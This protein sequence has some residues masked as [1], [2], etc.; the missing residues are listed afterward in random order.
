[1]LLAGV[2]QFKELDSGQN[3]S[4]QVSGREACRNDGGGISCF[5][6]TLGVMGVSREE[7]L[8][9]DDLHSLV[10]SLPELALKWG[11][12]LA[13]HTTFRVGGPVFCL[14]RPWTEGALMRLMQELT[15]LEAPYFILGGGSNLLFPDDA[16]NGL[17]IQLDLCSGNLGCNHQAGASP[18]H[19]L[20]GAGVRLS[21]L[22]RFCLSN[23]LGGIEFLVGI[24]GTVGGALVMNAGTTAG[25]IGDALLWIDVLDEN[26]RPR[27]ILRSDL[28]PGYRSLGLP[29]NWVVLGCCLAVEACAAAI[30]R[31][32]LAEI[33][34]E[35]KRTQPFGWPSAGCIFKNPEGLAAG[36][37]IEQSGLKGLRMGDAE[38]SLKHANWIINRGHARARDVVAL[39]EHIENHVHRHFGIHLEREIRIMGS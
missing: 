14:V 38:V 11:E 7:T 20:V 21:R 17:A 4:W 32:R 29:G 2:Q 22:L 26:S 1:V 3:L 5:V 30:Q 31:A 37:L 19:L 33:M 15:K 10:V 39:I 9:L 13:R 23:S 24:P 34:R 18:A 12:P 8:S 27:R 6:V 36:A 28:S 25:A 16:W 35:R